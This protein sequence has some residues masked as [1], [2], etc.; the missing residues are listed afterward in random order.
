MAAQHELRLLCDAFCTGL[1]WV[2]IGLA[3]FV[4]LWEMIDYLRSEPEP[5][6]PDEWSK[7][8]DEDKLILKRFFK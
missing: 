7:L 8:S 1:F 6:D 5:E 2:L 4:L 3:S